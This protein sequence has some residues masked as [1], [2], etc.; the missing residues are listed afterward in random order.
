MTKRLCLLLGSWAAS[1]AC[2][3]QL[4][5]TTTTFEARWK[6]QRIVDSTF[7]KEGRLRTRKELPLKP[8]SYTHL[9]ITKSQLVY[10]KRSDHSF[11]SSQPYTRQGDTLRIVS[12]DTT[13]TDP[14][15]AT[16]AFLDAHHLVL[17]LVQPH[18]PG[19][20]YDY[21]TDTSFYTR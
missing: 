9:L 8:T 17:R 2:Q 13:P 6:L 7:T 12:A 5:T 10:Q 19:W 3:R 20:R 14:V 16:I 21:S 15:L 11:A 4:G 1:T 18:P